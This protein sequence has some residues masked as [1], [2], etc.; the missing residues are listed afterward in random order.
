MTTPK[1]K[2]NV[3]PED[4]IHNSELI[5]RYNIGTGQQLNLLDTGKLTAIQRN[6][7]K[8]QPVFP[9]MDPEGWEKI[10]GKKTPDPRQFPDEGL[11]AKAKP[12]V[13]YRPL[14]A[15]EIGELAPE[16][17]A[18][19]YFLRSEVESLRESTPEKQFSAAE[20]DRQ[21]LRD[22]VRHGVKSGNI[23]SYDDLWNDPVIQKIQKR[24]NWSEDTIRKYARGCG[25]PTKKRGRKPAK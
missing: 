20:L 22:Q 6:I 2:K 16:K 9:S 23:K 14:S 24:R 5:Q 18:E 15:N 12:G 11:D 3:S 10:A 7:G 19:L 8:R 25:I 21:R 1:Q 4:L 17:V 13:K